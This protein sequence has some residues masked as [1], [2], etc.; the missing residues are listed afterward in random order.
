MS[1]FVAILALVMSIIC[2]PVSA[3]SENYVID[4][5]G[6]HA[7]IQ[8]KIKH[9]GYSWLYGRFNKFAGE[10]SFDEK[11]PGKASVEVRIE[12]GSIDSNHLKR[13]NHLRSK[14]FLDVTRFPEATFISRGVTV[15]DKGKAVV[16]GD[17]TLHGVTLPI[18]LHMAEVGAGPDP[19]GGFRRGFE[20]TASFSLADFGIDHNLGTASSEVELILSAEGVR[21]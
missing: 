4:A 15:T 19:W 7:F 6:S 13:D 9:L 11:E 16:H 20:G 10:F 5:K 14:D 2:W 17:L 1:K 12:V 21:Q 3:R 18:D 8:F